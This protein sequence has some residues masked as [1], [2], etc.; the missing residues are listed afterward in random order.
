MPLRPPPVAASVSKRIGEAVGLCCVCAAELDWM[1]GG[2]KDC[3]CSGYS[4][5]AIPDAVVSLFCRL[6]PATLPSPAYAFR[7][8]VLRRLESAAGPQLYARAHL[9]GQMI[10]EWGGCVG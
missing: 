1:S 2:V 4:D 10:P 6:M 7:P 3:D 5:P 8:Q 9:S